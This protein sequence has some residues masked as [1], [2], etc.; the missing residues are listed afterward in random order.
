[1]VLLCIVLLAGLV[2]VNGVTDSAVLAQAAKKDKDA[3]KAKGG[4]V[5]EIAEGKDSKFRFFVRTADG[6]LLAMSSPGG[7]ATEKEAAKA[8]DDLKEAISK[9]RITVKKPA[10]SDK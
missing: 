8:I 1:M 3:K 7:F 4:P 5:I 6:T 10:K 2:V 9:A